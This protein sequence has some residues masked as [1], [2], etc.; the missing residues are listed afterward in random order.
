MKKIPY[1]TEEEK[2]LIIQEELLGGLILAGECNLVEGNFLTFLTPE[3][4]LQRQFKNPIETDLLGQQ[5][6]EKELQILELQQENQVLG[7]QMV[8]IDLRLLMGGL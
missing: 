3:E 2:Q 1:G 7:Q 6:V 5:L 8:D 4:D